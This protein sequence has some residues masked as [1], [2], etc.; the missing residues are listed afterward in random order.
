MRKM[1]KNPSRWQP[2]T[3]RYDWF[4]TLWV[5]KP[6]QFQWLVT[7]HHLDDNIETML[8]HFFGVRASP[9]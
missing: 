3:S 9:V 1:K 7:A 6:E 5:M 8:M 4:K 2:E